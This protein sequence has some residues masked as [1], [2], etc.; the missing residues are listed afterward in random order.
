MKQ[1]RF[2][3]P[4][5]LGCAAAW[6]APTFN[7]DIAPILYGSCAAC[8]RPGEVAPFSLLSYQDAAKRARLIADVTKSRYM[9]PWKGE[10]GYGQFLHERRL[11]DEQISLLAQWAEAGA[12]EGEAADK[13]AP[14]SFPEGWQIGQ[15]DHVMK[16]AASFTVPADGPDQFRCF[17]LP[18]G[19]DRDVYVSGA[20]FRP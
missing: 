17:V 20:E 6:G 16:M 18:T 7:K 13:P 12:P 10:P 8:H 9:P 4:F 5:V 14:P 15:P 3:V 2:A 11:T 19:L 1:V